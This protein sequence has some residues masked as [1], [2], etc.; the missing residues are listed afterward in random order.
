MNHKSKLNHLKSQ[1]QIIRSHLL[2]G[3]SITSMEAFEEHGITRLPAIIHTLREY[4]KIPIETIR[5]QGKGNKWWGLN[6]I[7]PAKLK[8]ARQAVNGKY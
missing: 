2:A 3:E 6:Q 8:E 5:I 7:P 4:E 1:R